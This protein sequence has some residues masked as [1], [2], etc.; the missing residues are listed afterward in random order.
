VDNNACFEPVTLVLEPLRTVPETNSREHWQ[1]KHRR[2]KT[3]RSATY[4][5][6]RHVLLTPEALPMP[7]TITLTRISPRA[8]DDMAAT[9]ASMKS[10]QDGIADFLFQC[11]GEGHKYD[12]DPRLTW[13]YAQRQGGVRQYAVEMTFAA[14]QEAG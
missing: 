9:G 12:N 14:T 10:I 7:L 2:A 13:H 3:Q 1:K 6:L 4:Y 11:P 8:L 5:W